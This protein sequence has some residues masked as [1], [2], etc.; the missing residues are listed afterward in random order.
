MGGVT[1]VSKSRATGNM[2]DCIGVGPLIATFDNT[3]LYQD[4]LI[5]RGHDNTFEH[6]ERTTLL[7]FEAGLC[8]IKK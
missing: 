3:D 2:T 4:L 1:R 6:G 7:E 8:R 5:F